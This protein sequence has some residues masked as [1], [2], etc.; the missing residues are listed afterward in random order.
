MTKKTVGVV[1]V[2]LQAQHHLRSCLPPLLGSSLKPRVLVVD[3]S[4]DDGTVALAQEMGAETVVI[5]RA[6]F[7]HGTTRE[8]ARR[9][10]NTD[11]VV[12]I[13]QDAYGVDPDMLEH[14][15][16]PL[17]NGSASV[18]YARQI[19]HDDADFFASFHRAYNY[20]EKSHVR[21][22]KDAPTYGVYTLFCSNS[23]AAY[24]NS[25][26]DEIGGFKSVLLGEDTFAVADLLQK[27]HSIAY[28]SEAVVKH[29]HSYSL[30]QEFKRNFDTGIVRQ[31]YLAT[32][33]KFG[34][35]EAR[36]RDYVIKMHQQLLKKHPHLLPY[37]WMHT[38]AKWLGYRLGR[39]STNAPIWFKRALS[40]QKS[41][42]D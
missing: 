5:P 27:G 36:G 20:P 13:T 1:I 32:L 31:Q 25:A 35:D 12:M 17:R 33:K 19:P 8:L 9:H 7:N 11:I 38:L 26:L 29:S 34:T 3:S 40:S 42:W 22:M 10:L 2:T 41:F 30:K 15:T 21:S 37:A 4:S 24:L 6:S 28:V 18:A 23:C 14:L 39:S 16:L